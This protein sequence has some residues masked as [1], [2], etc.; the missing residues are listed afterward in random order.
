[1]LAI[2]ASKVHEDEFGPFSNLSDNVVLVGIYVVI[3]VLILDSYVLFLRTLLTFFKDFVRKCVF[4]MR[5]ITLT[6]FIL[7]LGW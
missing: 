5:N 4:S 7:K 2:G 3:Y 6:L 1:M